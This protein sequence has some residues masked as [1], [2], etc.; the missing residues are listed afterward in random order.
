MANRKERGYGDQL[1]DLPHLLPTPVAQ[2]SG[3][4]PEDHLRKKPGRT[5]VTD[6]AVIVENDLLK[7][8]GR[9][10]PTPTTNLAISGADYSRAQRPASGGDDLSTALHRELSAGTDFGPYT[11][12][13][14][15]W[16]NIIG[17]NPPSPTEVGTRNKFRLSAPFAE[18]MMGLPFGW[19]TS[20]ELDLTRSQAL[21][22]IG[23]GVVPL[24]AL[25]ALTILFDIFEKEGA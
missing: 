3:N 20:P 14:E 8:G 18:W 7:S 23:N 16:A 13:I 25:H 24:Q 21:A 6:L 1:N 2:P 15:R 5:Q 10:L 17:R 11:F 12:A 19:V 4:T 9:L 22:A